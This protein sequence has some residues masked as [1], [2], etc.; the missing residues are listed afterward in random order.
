MSYKDLTYSVEEKIATITL[1]RPERMNALS[2]NL[3]AEL[4][5][6]FDAADADRSVKVIILTGAGRAFC[7]GRDQGAAAQGGRRNAD[8]AGKSFAD[9]IEQWHRSDQRKLGE[10]T[11]MW[12][13][14]KPIIAAC[15]RRPP[16]P[17]FPYH[18][19]P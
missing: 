11:H 7:S 17:P 16:R 5:H 12:R 3:E 14:G 4:H 10:W 6:A 18:P 13:L 19:P 9:F 2:R 15:N 1:N 8:P